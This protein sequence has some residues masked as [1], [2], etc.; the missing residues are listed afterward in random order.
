LGSQGIFNSSKPA[1]GRFMRILKKPAILLEINPFL[2]YNKLTLAGSMQ[3]AAHFEHFVTS[4]PGKDNS[5]ASFLSD[6]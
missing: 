6:R 3:V 5:F 4:H 1:A 2:M